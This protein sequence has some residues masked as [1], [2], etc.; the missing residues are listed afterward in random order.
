MLGLIVCVVDKEQIASMCQHVVEEINNELFPFIPG[1]SEINVQV[2]QDNRDAAHWAGFASPIEIFH[3]NRVSGG[4][5]NAHGIESL[6]ASD[7]LEREEVQCNDTHR[8]DLISR[9]ILLPQQQKGNPS[10]IVARCL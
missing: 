7:E 6:V 5:V 2:P 4:D 8:F 10:L 3:P 9:M 1:V